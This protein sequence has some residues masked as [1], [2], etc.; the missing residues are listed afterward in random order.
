MVKQTCHLFGLLNVDTD[1]FVRDKS[2]RWEILFVLSHQHTGQVNVV[3]AKILR[4]GMK[5]HLA[6]AK[7]V[8]RKQ[9]PVFTPGGSNEH[10]RVGM[11]RSPKVQ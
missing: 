10:I 8:V 9:S 5:R 2:S 3:V 6:G 11:G 1:E 7:L 4:N